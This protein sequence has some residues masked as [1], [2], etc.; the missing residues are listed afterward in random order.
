MGGENNNLFGRSGKDQSVRK[1][2]KEL[3]FPKKS[4]KEL[5]YGKQL[6]FF[7]DSGKNSME[8]ARYA[9]DVWKN[10]G[11]NCCSQKIRERIEF[12]GKNFNYLGKNLIFPRNP[13]KEFNGKRASFW[14]FLWHT[15]VGFSSTEGVGHKL[16]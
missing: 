13:G 12:F 8:S 4:G 2:G 16:L 1:S 5:N 10:P 15:L 9:C 11:K 14:S 3:L 7:P 6:N